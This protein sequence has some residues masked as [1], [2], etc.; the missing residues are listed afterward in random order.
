M[1]HHPVVKRAGKLGA[2]LAAGT[3]AIVAVA[4]AAFAD[5]ST[6]QANALTLSLLSIT[7]GIEA[8]SNP[9][10]QP[11]VSAGDQPALSIL[12]NEHDV[13]VGAA[14][15]TATAFGNG[16]SAAC[17]GG[18]GNGGELQLGS[19]GTCSVNAGEAGGITVG[20]PFGTGLLD[21]NAAVETCSASST[22]PPVAN[23]QEL[24]LSIAGSPIAL[25][26]S[27]PANDIIIPGLLELNKQTVTGGKISATALYVAPLGLSIGNVTCG[28][29]AQTSP[30][31]VFPVK[32]L[33]IVGG[34]A[35]VCIAGGLVWWRRRGRRLT[36]SV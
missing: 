20:G 27:V 10:G 9:G 16:F 22:S 11:P 30:T 35:A 2:V 33:P 15:Q 5:T 24:N 8:A 31:S 32:S 23:A 13:T 19:D 7:T 28:P 18:F 29:N 1:R 12:A 6:A 34:T 36:A 21:V 17:A 26:P 14:Q 25:P 3:M 4:P